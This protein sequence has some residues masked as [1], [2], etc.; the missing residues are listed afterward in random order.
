VRK[1]RVF[2]VEKG[3]YVQKSVGSEFKEWSGR[4]RLETD[5][6]HQSSPQSTYLQQNEL[7]SAI[8]VMMP[9]KYRVVRIIINLFI[10]CDD[11][12]EEEWADP[13]ERQ[14]RSKGNQTTG[15]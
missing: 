6:L 13:G 8:S 10:F 5:L 9:A 7:L 4:K 12:Q 11:D 1:R 15:G 3:M 2:A 14:L